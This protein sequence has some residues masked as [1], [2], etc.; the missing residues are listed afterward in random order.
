MLKYN[1]IMEMKKSNKGTVCLAAVEQYDFPLVV[2]NI[3]HG[4]ISVYQA[5]QEVESDYLPKIYHV[6]ETEEG[7]LVAE[8]YIDGEVL[9]DYIRNGNLTEEWCID[10]A[11]QICEAMNCL[12][13]H[14]PPIIHR[15]IKPSNIIINSKG[16]LKLIDFDSA[17]LYKADID[18]DTRLLGTE[19]YAAPEQYG[20]SQTDCRSDIYSF[21]VVLEKFTGFLTENKQKQWK[22]LVEKCTL[23]A[24]DSRYQSVSEIKHELKRLKNK[25]FFNIRQILVVAGVILVCIMAGFVGIKISELQSKI[26]DLQA[27]Q[28]ET[29]ESTTTES[30]SREQS[31]SGSMES[32]TQES[33][34]QENEKQESITQESETQESITQESTTQEGEIQESITQESITQESVTQESITQESATQESITQES[35]TQEDENLDEKYREIPPE[36]RDLKSEI[37]AYV[38]LK[39]QIRE[40][41]MVVMYCFKDR[42]KERDFYVHVRELDSDEVQFHGVWLYSEK[43]GQGYEIEADYVEIRNNVIAIDK[44]YMNN[45]ENG[46]YRLA[47]V[48]SRGDD[49]PFEHSIF[50]YVASSDVLE[51]PDMWLQNTTYDYNC[52]KSEDLHLVLKNDSGRELASLQL[53][54]GSEIDSSMYKVVENGRVME[55][56][57]ELL[58]SFKK[59]G[60]LSYNV[61]CKDGSC[62]SI[63]IN[64]V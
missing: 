38:S 23:F 20:F 42:M 55:I 19:K 36:F 27:A 33:V 57:S 9:T 60:V 29:T 17:R 25:M 34:T 41:N 7:L 64:G 49:E 1:I 62:M 61:V 59:G 43:T 14:Q 18:N 31:E 40:Y 4:N 50:L 11:N 52:G 3:K 13:N 37:P 47:T 30:T 54:N 56:S 44:E 6:E 5:L 63:S 24:P 21:G 53:E 39:E 35:T 45:L 22:R 58:R 46:Y 16:E 10:I 2:K 8:E 15:D 12:H 26:D 48:I 32:A 28:N 51:E